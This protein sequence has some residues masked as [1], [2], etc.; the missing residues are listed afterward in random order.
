MDK[1]EIAVVDERAPVFTCGDVLWRNKYEPFVERFYINLIDEAVAGAEGLRAYTRAST[2]IEGS[3]VFA[4]ADVLC[5][6]HY[7]V[8]AG[9]WFI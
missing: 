8:G 7:N 6:I 3:G 5:A 2:P 4:A 1:V 9:P